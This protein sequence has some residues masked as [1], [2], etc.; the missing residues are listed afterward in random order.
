MPD[1]CHVVVGAGAVGL[2][3][4]VRLAR[5]SRSVLIL[6][7]NHLPGQETSSRNSEVIHAGLYHPPASLKSKLCIR[8]KNLIYE[9][10]AK[11][12][13]SLRKCG[14][15]IVA[16]TPKESM[17]LNEMKRRAEITGVPLRWVSLD[18]AKKAEPEVIAREAILES[19]TTGII[20]AHELMSWYEAEF[21]DAGGDMAT[22]TE[23]TGLSKDGDIYEVKTADDSVVTASHVINA[24]GHYAPAISNLLLPTQRHLK[25]YFGKG[26][27]FS[28]SS[29]KPRVDRLIYPCPSDQGSLGTH[30]TLDLQGRIKFGPDLEWVDSPNDLSVNCQNLEKAK[31][32]I[33][34]YLNIDTSLLVPDYAGIR[35]KLSKNSKSFQDF[36][37]R[38]EVGFPGFINLLGIESPGLTASMAI[39][40]YVENLVGGRS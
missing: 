36:I 21:Q 6:E 34:K 4:G 35:P 17:Y 38:E 3:I 1:F 32:A 9:R 18:E 12:G 11:A 5:A 30:L 31:E 40:E 24:A 27:Y 2:A 29:T 10:A 16:Q 37:I 20:S 23:V 39:A 7:K 13:V 25:P 22:C 28:Y 33:L 26:N 8:G 19:P 14:K 15:W